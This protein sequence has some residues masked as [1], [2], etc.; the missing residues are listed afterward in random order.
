MTFLDVDA[1]NGINRHFGPEVGDR[2]VEQ[3]IQ[4]LNRR[5]AGVSMVRI[6]S[7]E[8]VW[9]VPGQTGDQAVELA[10]LCLRDIRDHAWSRVAPELFV[11]ASCGVAPSA[12][13]DASLDVWVIRAMIGGREAK[14]AGGNRVLA[15]P[16]SLSRS[17]PDSIYDYLS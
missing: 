16:L 13:T 3:V 12:P 17:A 14:K 4:I 11:T 15:G 5:L 2:V 6:G 1:M 7:D 10:D 9:C 8:F